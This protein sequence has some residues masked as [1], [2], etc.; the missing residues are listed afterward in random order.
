MSDDEMRELIWGKR[1][2]WPD[3]IRPEALHQGHS[4]LQVLQ[5]DKQGGK[6]LKRKAAVFTPCPGLLSRIIEGEWLAYRGLHQSQKIH[7]YR[8]IYEEPEDVDKRK[9][10]FNLGILW[11]NDDVLGHIKVAISLLKPDGF[12]FSP[13]ELALADDMIQCYTNVQNLLS[14]LK[15]DVFPQETL[16]E[17]SK[18][19]QSEDSDANLILNSMRLCNELHR[20][21]AYKPNYSVEDV[22]VCS[23]ASLALMKHAT[24]SGEELYWAMLVSSKVLS[25]IFQRLQKRLPI[26]TILSGKVVVSRGTVDCT[27]FGGKEHGSARDQPDLQEKYDQLPLVAMNQTMEASEGLVFTGMQVLAVFAD[28]VI[29]WYWVRGG[30]VTDVGKYDA[31]IPR[32]VAMC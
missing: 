4:K 28:L 27:E 12:F 10:P 15:E 19:K 5:D 26:K 25:G 7:E 11:M 14:D 32:S 18:E 21:Q 23:K 6:N 16:D 22:K 1:S 13:G 30:M 17:W 9:Y 29:T 2:Q 31:T 3:A 8:R 20:R 24:A